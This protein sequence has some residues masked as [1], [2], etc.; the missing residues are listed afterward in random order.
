MAVRVEKGEQ[1]PM[2]IEDGCDGPLQML[3]SMI[4]TRCVKFGT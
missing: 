4:L 1:T 2:V 3:S